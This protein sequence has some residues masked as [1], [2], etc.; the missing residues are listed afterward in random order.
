MS[1]VQTAADFI[2]SKTAVRPEVAMVLGSGL[3]SLSD[4][5]DID[6]EISYSDIPGFFKPT[7]YGHA[8]KLFVGH[9]SGRACAILSG[10]FHMYEGHTAAQAAFPAYVMAKIGVKKI[11]YTNAAGAVNT[12]FSVGDLMLIQDHI[13]LM[14][15]SPIVNEYVDELGVRFVDMSTAYTPALLEKAQQAG[16]EMGILLRKGVYGM[17]LGPQFETPAEIRMARLLGADAVGMSTVPEVIGARHCGLEILG[18]SCMTNM[19]AGIL[20]QPITH[21]EVLETGKRVEDKMMKLLKTL[22]PLL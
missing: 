21:Q 8:G 1:K 16:R 10:R 14:G 5:M 6:A 18:F 22:V 4:I 13:N 2:L 9:V 19:A 7:A 11:I 15:V 20:D 17:F 3:G 12:D